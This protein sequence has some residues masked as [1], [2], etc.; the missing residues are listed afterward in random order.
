[1]VEDWKMKD[2]AKRKE[3]SKDLK[4]VKF[5]TTFLLI[6]AVGSGV[7]FAIYRIFLIHFSGLNEVSNNSSERLLYMT[8][9]F[10]F[11]VQISPIYEI[12][13][14]GQ[15]I[16]GSFTATAYVVHDGF[17]MIAVYHLCG[18]LNVLRLDISNLIDDSERKTF[19]LALKPILQ[20]YLKLKR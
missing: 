3:M 16:C 1:M 19:T 18:Q 14:I 4:F 17:F 2:E 9:D 7:T 5:M 8:S 15:F 13:W 6:N 10:S 20:R 12:I 11:S